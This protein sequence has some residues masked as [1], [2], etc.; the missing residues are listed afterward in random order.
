[1]KRPFFLD[2]DLNK[3]IDEL[4]PPAPDGHETFLLLLRGDIELE[5][6]WRNSES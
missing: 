1:M 6:R 2:V 4:K 3:D 5:K